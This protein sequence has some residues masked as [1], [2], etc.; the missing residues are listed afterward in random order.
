MT[1]TRLIF[2]AV[3][4]VATAFL[5]LDYPASAQEGVEARVTPDRLNVRLLPGT[6]QPTIGQFTRDT[7]IVV[8]G[9][10]DEMGNGGVW[11]YG[12]PAGGGLTGWVLWEYLEWPEGFI[13][14]TLPVINAEGV[15]GDG[16]SG[17]A[18]DDTPPPAAG[19]EGSLPAMTV[20]PVNFR[21]GPG[22]NYGIIRLLTA[23]TP[24]AAIGRNSANT[25]FQVVI[26][27]Q[28]GW[29]FHTLVDISGDVNALPVVEVAPPAGGGGGGVNVP[30]AYSAANLGVFSY[31]AHIQNFSHPNLMHYAG[32]SWVKVQVRYSW[33]QDASAVAGLINQAHGQ[34]FRI[35]LGVVGH[36]NDILAGEA[37]FQAYANFV[38][39]AAALGADAI[40]VWNEPNLDR[41]W[42]HG[43][44]NPATY[45][46]L[47]AH[48]YNNIKANNP[49]T[50]VISAAPAPTGAEGWFGLDA[51][52]NDDHYLSGMAAAGAARYMDCLGAHYNEGIVSPYT[53]SGDPRG[54]NYYTRY[55]WGMINRYRSIIAKPICFTELGYLSPEGYGPLPG[56]FAWASSTTVAQQARW[57]T[58]A[59]RISRGSG[60][61]KL[62]IIWNMN[63]S[64]THGGDPMGGYALIRPDGSCPACD[65]LAA[66]N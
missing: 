26:G 20:N 61:V 18:G 35:L 17:D 55:L 23:N 1:R 28:E 38:G 39:G 54:D 22:T 44:I 37:Y 12:A 66:I 41:E 19:P 24:G 31:G 3:F 52:W 16:G 34:G 62:V 46:Q 53:T 63:F 36:P 56:A 25:W 65:A 5:S 50:I 33:G 21:Q 43:H 60:V 2:L 64:G 32:M 45:T 42:P 51:V 29:L 9:R 14:E 4:L 40:E 58:D 47:L 27:D 59:V 6:D 8:Q 11:V 13:V 7:I 15:A 49:G 10:E 48:A 30:A 57:V